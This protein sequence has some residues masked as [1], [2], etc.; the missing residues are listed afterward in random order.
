MAS[1]VM[2]SCAGSGG[3][4]HGADKQWLADKLEGDKSL[5]DALVKN[6][7]VQGNKAR[8]TAKQ[9]GRASESG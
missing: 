5:A 9:N 7:E 1:G 4:N 2:R 6:L 3:K 8:R